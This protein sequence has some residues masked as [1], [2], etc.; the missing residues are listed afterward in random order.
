MYIQYIQGLFQS[1]HDTA[2]YA[3]VTS[4][5][6]YNDSL[7]TWTVIHMTAAKFKPL[8]FS[9]SGFALSNV[10]NILIFMIL[11]EF[12]LLS[13]WFCYVIINVW[14]MKS[15][16]HISN[17][18]AFRK[19]ANCAENLILQSNWATLSL[20]GINT[21]TLQVGRVSNETVIYGNGSCTTR[22]TNC[23]PG[24]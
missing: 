8:I 11:D 5:L 1:R 23:R 4:S 19:I 9:V 6:H 16:M 2:D 12:C 15:L 22:T 3:L 14:Y 7:D 24:L 18:F 13:A 10:A 20:R 17:R 21:G